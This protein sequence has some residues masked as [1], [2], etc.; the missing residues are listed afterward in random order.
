MDACK[1]LT[2][3]AVLMLTA[4]CP[5]LHDWVVR[6][7]NGQLDQ[8]TLIQR[9]CVRWSKSIFCNI[10]GCCLCFIKIVCNR[11]V[12]SQ[13]CCIFA[14]FWKVSVFR[15]PCLSRNL[16]NTITFTF[17]SNINPINKNNITNSILFSFLLLLIIPHRT[18]EFFKAAEIIY[19][20]KY[21]IFFHRTH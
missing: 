13:T 6:R 21:L 12:L 5:P 9:K 7:L 15:K 2:I 17:Y 4:M 8:N 16:A 18:N 10:D 3:W 11:A 20:I 1:K 14:G 19:E